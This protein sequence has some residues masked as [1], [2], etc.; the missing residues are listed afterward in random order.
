MVDLALRKDAWKEL[1]SLPQILQCDL[2]TKHIRRQTTIPV[3]ESLS[4]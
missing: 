3:A 1:S 4:V 2:V